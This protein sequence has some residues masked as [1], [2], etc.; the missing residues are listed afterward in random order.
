MFSASAIIAPVCLTGLILAQNEKKQS[1]PIPQSK[2]APQSEVAP[3]SESAPQSEAAPQPQN[4]PGR[5][6]G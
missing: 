1:E 2:L 4:K 5:T 3:E 6:Q